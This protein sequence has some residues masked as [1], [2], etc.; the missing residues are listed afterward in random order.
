MDVDHIVSRKAYQIFITKA[1]TRI[2][3][4]EVNGL[5]QAAPSIVIPAEVHQKY[6]E[7]YGGRNSRAKQH[8]DAT[9]LRKAVD[10]NLDA[11]KPGLIKYGFSEVEVETARQQLHQLH[12]EKG[13]Y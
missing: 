8:E 7:T 4:K 11:L 13:I 5:L 12:I 1:F 6:S 10:S 2:S 9:D 3:R